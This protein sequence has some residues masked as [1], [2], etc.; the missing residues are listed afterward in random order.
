MLEGFHE[1]NL[2]NVCE[3]SSF[4][5]KKKSQMCEFTIGV[6]YMWRSYGHTCFKIVGNTLYMYEIFDNNKIC[7]YYPITN[8]AN[9]SLDYLDALCLKENMNLSFT[10]LEQSELEYLQKRY[11]HIKTYSCRDWEDYFYDAKS[12]QTF[13]GNHLSSKRHN[14]NKFK[15][16]YPNYTFHIAT[17][18]D[19][20]K[21]K[22]FYEYDKKL[23][24]FDNKNEIEEYQIS[25]DLI[26]NFYKLNQICGY[27]TVDDKIM[28]YSI[29][30]KIGDTLFVHLEK[31]LSSEIGCY[32][33]I[34]YEFA[35]YFGDSIKYINREDDNGDP[36]LRESKTQYHPIKLIKKN[37][38]KVENSLDLVKTLPHIVINDDVYLDE[39]KE[40]D[41]D[42][43]FKLTVDDELNKYWGYDYR[44]DIPQD[45]VNKDNVF[46]MLLKDR[47]EKNDFS[48]GIFNKLSLIGEV[49]FHEIQSDNT[50]EVGI[51]LFKEYQNKGIATSCLKQ[52]INFAFK[53]LNYNNLKA[54]CYKNNVASMKVILNNGFQKTSEDNNFYYFELV[55]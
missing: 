26:E 43:Y 3:L 2:E 42:N 7:F 32:Q 52:A 21:I 31:A 45:I 39:I 27:I 15:K 51:R 38:L 54:K 50:S 19:I 14:L 24:D 6:K 9:S 12:L 37:F 30:E 46:E 13:G 44:V 16:N 34:V 53:T 49:V 5:Y 25:L 22:K 8:D 17:A 47:Q 29:G 48:F 28:A 18:N 55:I 23:I 33:A 36:G 40:K 1:I 35:N 11:K 10:C 20:N 4:L 41:K